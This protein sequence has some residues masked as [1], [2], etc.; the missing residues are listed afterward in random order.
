MQSPS[1]ASHVR[2]SAIMRRQHISTDRRGTGKVPEKSV[3]QE[4]QR[5]RKVVYT[6]KSPVGT[7]EGKIKGSIEKYGWRFQWPYHCSCKL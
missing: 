1:F 3:T 2:C 6:I 7:L 4:R 5:D